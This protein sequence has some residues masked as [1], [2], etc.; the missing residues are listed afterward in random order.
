MTG[1][2]TYT[3]TA[4]PS[5][6]FDQAAKVDKRNLLDDNL[7]PEETLPPK[8]PA[9][10]LAHDLASNQWNL[11]NKFLLTISKIM[12]KGTKNVSTTTN[13]IQSDFNINRTI[14]PTIEQHY[15][16]CNNTDSCTQTAR[17]PSPLQRKADG[18]ILSNDNT[19]QERKVYNFLEQT[20]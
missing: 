20:E 9:E 18:R 7:G 11:V 13:N 3:G 15:Q 17:H 19:I 14:I 2:D 6:I 12:K 8:R 10:I 5:S 1:A 16:Q 4:G